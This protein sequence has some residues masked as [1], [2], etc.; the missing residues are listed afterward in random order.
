[1]AI[2][3]FFISKAGFILGEK[4]AHFCPMLIKIILE[5]RNPGAAGISRAGKLHILCSI[6]ALAINRPEYKTGLR[7]EEKPR[8]A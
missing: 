6:S 7:V 4:K 3:G 8:K 2:L 1:M 5:L